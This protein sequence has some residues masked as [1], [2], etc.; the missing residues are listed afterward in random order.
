MWYGSRK[1]ASGELYTRI[2]NTAAVAG[3]FRHASESDR[4]GKTDN[5][6][7]NRRALVTG[8]GRVDDKRFLMLHV[9]VE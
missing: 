2:G 3:R 6:E 8:R 9:P 4:M 5:L 7:L 1:S